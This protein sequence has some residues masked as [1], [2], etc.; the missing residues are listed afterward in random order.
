MN[1]YQIL[2]L[3]DSEDDALLLEHYL[4]KKGMSARIFRV[5]CQ[6]NLLQALEQN[7]DLIISDYNMPGFSGLQALK[8]VRSRF[9]E[10]PFI[11]ISGFLDEEA[12][13]ELMRAGAQDFIMKSKLS[14]LIPAIQREMSEKEKRQKD[15]ELRMILEAQL[16]QAQKLEALGRLVSG[17]AHD[18]NNLLTVII[19]HASCILSELNPDDACYSSSKVIMQTAVS[20][21]SLT[22]KLLSFSRPKKQVVEPLCLNRA[23]EDMVVILSGLIRKRVDLQ[24]NLDPNLFY[25]VADR[26]QIEQIIMNLVI[27]ASDAIEGQGKIV[28]ETGNA[29]VDKSEQNLSQHLDNGLYVRLRVRDTGCG[30]NPEN[31]NKIFNAFFTTKE[32]GKGTGLGLAICNEIVKQYK[33]AI[34]VESQPGK[35]T[36]FDVYFSHKHNGNLG[37]INHPKETPDCYAGEM[38]TAS[39]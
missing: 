1:E 16:Q 33:G 13:V 29:Y 5:D 11:V 10:L 3:E 30:I 7:W 2:L 32:E 22:Q 14:R 21:S 31:I 36:V 20:A 9:A 38:Y 27:N 39:G 17:V 15:K 34:F 19:G 23:L 4:Q 12:A 18:F 28:L 8:L 25:L 24:L 6:E 26:T 37:S 35:G